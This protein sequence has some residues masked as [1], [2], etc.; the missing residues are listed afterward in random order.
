[1][2]TI[3]HPLLSIFKTIAWFSLAIV[4]VVIVLCL[5]SLGGLMMFGAFFFEAVPDAMMLMKH[6]AIFFGGVLSF[7]VGATIA[8]FSVTWAFFSC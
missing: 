1:M 7:S 4:I 5:M 8:V 2:L 6:L 3:K